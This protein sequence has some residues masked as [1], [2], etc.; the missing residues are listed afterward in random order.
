MFGKP[1]SSQPR[2]GLG[3]SGALSHVYIQYPPLRCS[4]PG[5]RGFFYDDGNKLLISPT[6]DQVFSW[7]VSRYASCDAP[8]SDS[9]SEGPVLSI[10]YSLD[11]NIIAIQRSNNEI[12]FRNQGTGSTFN[13]RCRSDHILGFFWT[14]CP[15]CDIVIIKSSGVDM[16]SY[17]P[18]LNALRLVDSKRLNVS[19]YVHTH[20]SRLV[21]LA[22]GMQCKSLTGFQFSSGGI[23]RLPRFDITMA[24]AEANQKPV[25]LAEDVHI[26]TIAPI[27]APLPLLVRGSPGVCSSPTRAITGQTTNVLQ[28]TKTDKLN[29]DDVVVYGDGWVFLAP[30]LICDASHGTLWRICLDLEAIAASSSDTPSLLEF[31]QQRRL[32]SLKAKRLCL[33]IMRTA[34]LERR[35]L[36]MIAKAMGVLS[37]SYSHSLKL[38]SSLQRGSRFTSQRSAFYTGATSS[39]LQH[40]SS[41]EVTSSGIK[42][43]ATTREVERHPMHLNRTSSVSDSEDSVNLEHVSSNLEEPHAISNPRD[44]SVSKLKGPRK[45]YSEAETSNP[46]NEKASIKSDSGET[47]GDS[48]DSGVSDPQSFEAPS[49][50]VS[51]NEMY[52]SVFALV[53]E[54]MA[55]DPAYLVAV[56]VEYFRSA[57]LE[58]LKV[59]PSLNILIIQLLARNDRYA[60]IQLFVV[61]KILEPSKEVALQLLE[62]GRHNLPTRK[63]G[64][65]MLRQL[66]LHNDYVLMLLQDGYYLEAIRY[67][68]RNKVNTIRPSLFLEAAMA[69]NDPQHLASVLRFFS[70][71][72]PD[73]RNTSDHS[74]FRSILNEMSRNSAACVQSEG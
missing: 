61:N 7:Q 18:Q 27:S 34:I 55:G 67:V 21:L 28:S 71:F 22:S 52:I 25:L 37:S 14:D 12:E 39:S 19:W 69:S 72:L 59:H 66:L 32:D 74:T 46:D 31:L 26:A 20:E 73:F 41:T 9:V 49:V 65:D 60:E 13:H 56:I 62:S 17:E 5:A 50:T 54:E 24:R 23:I 58:K 11:G 43:E 68:R 1:S 33:V 16:C 47:N 15:T 30:D 8:S 70:E 29:E 3:G 42:Q 51:P 2:I 57:A 6:T 35:S 63:L 38:G 64:M 48:L 4:I 10:R 40:I 44:P 36:P 53:E 45:N